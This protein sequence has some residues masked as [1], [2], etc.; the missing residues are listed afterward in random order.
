M[1]SA[2]RY[3]ARHGAAET[4][5][6]RP[7]PYPLPAHVI[8]V[9][10][11]AEHTLALERVLG[12]LAQPACVIAVINAPDGAP[13]AQA[14][15]S[16]AHLQHLRADGLLT[17]RTLET[18]H[19]RHLLLVVDRT[20]QPIPAKHGVGG[21]R[22][23]GMDIGLEMMARGW[24][25]GRWLHTTD[26]DAMLPDRYL[27]APLPEAG[28]VL[29]PFRHVS[30]DPSIA[31]RAALYEAHMK[32]YR[33][34]LERAGSPY[35]YTALGSCM[36]V[37][38]DTYVA[39][40]GMPRRDGGEDF[41]FANKAAKVAPVV[42]LSQPRITLKARLSNRVPFGTG[43]ALAG[44]AEHASD[45]LTYSPAVFDGLARLLDS[46][47]GARCCSGWEAQIASRLG[48]GDA[49]SKLERQFS[50][51][52]LTSALHTWFDA[53]KTLRFVHMAQRIHPDI[54]LARVLGQ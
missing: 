22:R 42:S 26:A 4:R 13:A 6:L 41:H 40:R 50:G 36:A 30:S 24:T 34:Q 20:T 45:Y 38:C 10:A 48:L 37:H 31:R 15:R 21:A 27:Q 32:H 12:D 16:R 7:P 23:I 53:L 9:P 14:A 44:A 2:A 17:W 3:L 52:R 43:P 1:A 5:A 54:P 25:A 28:L 11:Y 35:A 18:E 19:C 33:R 39:V 29:Y 47:H 49:R 8:I 46:F 51:N